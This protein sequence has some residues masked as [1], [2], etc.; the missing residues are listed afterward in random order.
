MSKTDQ[1]QTQHE[2]IANRRDKLNRWREAGIDP[3]PHTYERSH[4]SQ[5]V[6][7]QYDAL[8]GQSVSVAGRIVS[9]RPHGKS[10]FFHIL[11]GE[12]K[13]QCYA[14]KDQLGDEPYER[15]GWLDLGDFVGVTGEVFKT[16]TGETTVAVREYKLLAKALRPL[17]EKWHGLVDKETR[18]RQRYLDLV[19]NEEVRE[20]F[21]VRARI[22]AAIRNFLDARGFLEV[23]TPVLQPIYGGAAARPFVTHHNALD[24]QFYLR[25]ADELYLK[26]LLVGG[27]ERVYE[28]CRDFRNEGIDRD[29]NPEFTMVELY[30]AYFD[31]RDIMNLFRELI[32]EVTTAARGKPSFEF[33]G[34]D[35]DLTKPWREVPLL[36]IIKEKTGLDFSD[37]NAE[38]ARKGAESIGVDIPDDASYGK[39]VDDVFSERVQ[40]ELVE[41]TFL[42]DYPLEISPLAKR[43]REKAGLVER[44]E[45]FMA[46]REVGNAFSELNDP[47][48]QRARF[49][50]MAEAARRGDVE[51]H[52]VDEDF[53][54]ALEHG[55]PPTGGL[56][57]GVDRLTMTLTGL[58]SIREVILF[59]T[60]RPL[61][62]HATEPSAEG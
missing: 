55:M 7:E 14:K 58:T 56:G 27:Y 50:A 20:V 43:H 34:Q 10:T 30:A 1:T 24:A 28:V 32:I 11:D 23:E 49:E 3:Y 29:H 48:D 13:L 9:L 33:N 44:F 22:I 19:S 45:L 26:R 62:S 40:P 51:A 39:I 25:I 38:K 15:L 60:L 42:T 35:V 16:R 18:Y 8:E 12:G 41:P 54:T 53:L 46:A 47:D 5:D 17:P 59:P 2:L 36:D 52:Q 61:G 21:R 31:Y 37:P 6:L 4:K 57:F